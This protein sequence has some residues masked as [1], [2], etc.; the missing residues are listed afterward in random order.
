MRLFIKKKSYFFIFLLAFAVAANWHCTEKTEKQTKGFSVKN[1]SAL[2]N[3]DNYNDKGQKYLMFDYTNALSG[4]ILPSENQSA[5]GFGF[6]FLIKNTGSAPRSFFYKIYYQNDTYKFQE[7]DEA[8]KS[9]QHPLACEN[10][11]G[12]WD[13]TDLLFLET[14]TIPADGKYHKV[15]S[16]LRIAGNPRDE[17]RYYANG[18]SQRWKRNPRVGD[19]SF[20]LV[21][22]THE[23]IEKEKIP[24]GVQDISHAENGQF[25]NPFHFFQYGKGSELPQTVVAT[26]SK[27][28]NTM[29]RPEMQAGIYTAPGD[30]RDFPTDTMT[31]NLCNASQ[32]MRAKASFQQFIHYIDP[33]TRFS[34]IPVIRDVLNDGYTLKEYNWNKMFF[35]KEE[36][37]STTPQTA[38][39]PCETVYYSPEKNAIVLQNPGSKY[40]QWRKENA[41][42]RTIHSFTYGKYTLKANL[43]QLLNNDGL[44]NGIVNTMWL[45]NQSNDEWNKRR[46]CDEGGYMATYWGGTEDERVPHVSYSEIDFEILKT[47]PYCPPYQA[48]PVYLPARPNRYNIQEWH[49][50]LPDEVAEQKGQIVVAC[51]NWDMACWAPEN[52]S[53]GCHAIS[54]KG[55]EFLSHRW[56][57]LYRAVTQKSLQPDE[58]LFGQPYYFQIEWKPEEIIWRIGPDRKNLRIVG[59]MDSSITSIPNNQ[60][61]L[62]VTQEFHNTQWWVGAPFQQ[63]FIPFPENDIKG[64]IYEITIE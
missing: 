21:V 33:S 62:I 25:I 45:L 64:Y 23:N 63:G 53:Q 19:Y 12:S 41:A 22:T 13:N 60:M 15:T 30:F 3:W 42:V 14:P 16:Y 11:Y 6:E 34:N 31:G 7:Y 55:K 57:S 35:R 44:W 29:A 47:V 32:E 52:F 36:M 20:M 59:Y 18:K 39:T 26:Q 43:T 48:Q 5:E 56:D 50:P 8:D 10:F 4:F 1:F 2:Y 28:L 9:L 49:K 38:A 61:F 51:T 40:G 46:L 17:K 37:V 27:H 24:L 54:Y 58:E